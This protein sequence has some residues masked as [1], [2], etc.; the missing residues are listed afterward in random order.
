MSKPHGGNGGNGGKKRTSSPPRRWHGKAASIERAAVAI[1]TVHRS[2]Q[3]SL[4][5]TIAIAPPS[6]PAFDIANYKLPSVRPQRQ[7]TAE[8]IRAMAT[9]Q[10]LSQGE[11]ETLRRLEAEELAAAE[12]K[13]SSPVR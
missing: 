2:H 5:E 10:P 12:Q 7:I 6:A 11:V 3:L 9:W 13:R 8:S 4:F 1:A